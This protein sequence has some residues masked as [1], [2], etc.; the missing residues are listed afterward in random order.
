[1]QMV[2]IGMHRSGTSMVCRLINMMGAYFGPEGCQW[3]PNP[4]N[5]RGFWERKDFRTLNDDILESAGCTWHEVDPWFRNE[6]DKAAE[7][8]FRKRAG[9]LI[10][11]MEGFRPWVTKEPRFCL[12]FPYFLPHLE[13]PVVILVAR[14]PREVALS[15]QARDGFAIEKGLRLWRQYNTE[16]LR[17]SAPCP[18]IVVNHDELMAG[19][20]AE[21][22]RLFE[23]LN[24]LG[25]RGLRLPSEREILGFIDPQLH[26]SID[27]GKPARGPEAELYGRLLNA[28]QAGAGNA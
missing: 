26:R 22:S 6:H 25:V 3:D 10:F 11:R 23:T 9:Q 1:M 4:E 27:S 5:P 13:F 17:V 12:T 21:V 18:R 8:G 7:P 14:S 19:P 16:A 15:L 28:A 2:V 20:V 24:G